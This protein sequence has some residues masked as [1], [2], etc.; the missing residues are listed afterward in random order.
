M[1][2]EVLH[3]YEVEEIK[4]VCISYFSHCWDKTPNRDNFRDGGFGWLTV[5]GYTVHHG[6]KLWQWEHE[7][8]GHMEATVRKQRAMD[9]G[10]G[11]DTTP[12]IQDPSPWSVIA[13]LRSIFPPQLT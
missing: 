11:F 12:T 8:A 7:A 3:G 4:M 10:A 9:A 6:G 13:Q 2:Y 5:R 1:S